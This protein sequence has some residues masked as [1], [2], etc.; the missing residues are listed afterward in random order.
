[1]NK[2]FLRKQKKIIFRIIS[3][4]VGL[5]RS[6]NSVLYKECYHQPWSQKYK[7]FKNLRNNNFFSKEF[8]F[9]PSIRRSN[10]L[11]S[12]KSKVVPTYTHKI[13]IVQKFLLHTLQFTGKYFLIKTTFYLNK[14]D[15]KAHLYRLHGCWISLFYEV[16]ISHKGWNN[17]ILYNEI[18]NYF[19]NMGNP[20]YD[21]VF[22]KK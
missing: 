10:F 3:Y 11:N 15:S 1:M 8:T 13:L 17:H 20:I 14:K 12:T 2:A 6:C 22:H 21:S 19:S 5:Y 18:S 9:P 4:S 16:C 7:F